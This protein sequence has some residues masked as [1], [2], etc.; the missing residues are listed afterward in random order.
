MTIENQFTVVSSQNIALDDVYVQFIA[1]I[2]ETPQIKRK[3][4]KVQKCGIC[5]FFAPKNLC[6]TF[7]CFSS[8]TNY[9]ITVKYR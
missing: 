3:T 9:L 2:Y 8:L 5:A 1:K 7:P 4:K 6:L